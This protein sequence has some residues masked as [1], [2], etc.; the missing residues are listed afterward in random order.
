MGGGT[1]EGQM[2]EWL[3]DRLKTSWFHMV[4]ERYYE[5]HHPTTHLYLEVTERGE[6]LAYDGWDYKRGWNKKGNKL[7]RAEFEIGHFERTNLRSKVSALLSFARR[8]RE[9]YDW[10]V[11]PVLD[12][13]EI[14]LR[15]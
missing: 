13:Y 11:V 3:E 4:A 15:Q 1:T 9:R 7:V 12:R 2:P 14:V 5:T 8:A 10:N 6:I